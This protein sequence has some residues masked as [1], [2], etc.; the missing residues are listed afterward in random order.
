MITIDKWTGLIT[1]ASP[2]AKPP[3]A[4]VTQV[5]LQVLVPGELSTRSGVTS[6]T[7][8]AHTGSTQPVVQCVHFQHSTTPHIVYQ[9][10]AGSVF[11]AKGP[12]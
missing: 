3:T 8:A 1:N 10:S 2:Y 6:V 7:F 9:N 4:A 5:N 11:V 12:S